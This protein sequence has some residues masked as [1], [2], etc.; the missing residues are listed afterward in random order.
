MFYPFERIVVKYRGLLVFA[1]F[2]R[3]LIA[4]HNRRVFYC[5]L[6]GIFEYS[7]EIDAKRRFLHRFFLVIE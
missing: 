1:N 5:V 3:K 7:G 2:T 6:L 4:C